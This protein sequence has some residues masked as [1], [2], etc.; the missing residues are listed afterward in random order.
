[1][2]TCPKQMETRR[3]QAWTHLHKHGEATVEEMIGNED[4]IDAEYD[5]V[6][7][8]TQAKSCHKIED[9][10]NH[11]VDHALG[12]YGIG[13]NTK[14]ISCNKCHAQPQKDW[15]RSEVEVLG[16]RHLVNMVRWNTD[17]S[18]EDQ[19]KTPTQPVSPSPDLAKVR[20]RATKDI[21][22]NENE[23]DCK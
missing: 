12:M 7:E 17:T 11:M 2:A 13:V 15:C 14:A 1:M 6:T 20:M 4:I 22:E 19:Q 16:E 10:T 21:P 3:C 5:N 23:T 9:L 18:K 8:P